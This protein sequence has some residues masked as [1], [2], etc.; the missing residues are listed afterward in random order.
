MII[1]TSL[2]QCSLHLRSEQSVGASKNKQEQSHLAVLM[3]LCV[4]QGINLNT[5]D[6]A[7]E[8][9]GLVKVTSI[10]AT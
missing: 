4:K 7:L 3:A 9:K 1:I 6:K 8:S 5:A 10:K 2:H